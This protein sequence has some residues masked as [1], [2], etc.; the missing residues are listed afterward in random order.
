LPAIL[1]TGYAD[2]NS[3]ASRPADVQV[4]GK[5]FTPDQLRAAIRCAVGACEKVA[6]LVGVPDAAE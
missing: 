1:I 5:P 6:P 2:A 4:L 3:I